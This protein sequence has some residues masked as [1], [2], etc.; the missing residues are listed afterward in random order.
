MLPGDAWHGAPST[1]PTTSRRPP[2]SGEGHLACPQLPGAGGCGG[3]TAQGWQRCRRSPGPPRRAGG[4]A[5]AARS[6]FPALPGASLRLPP[7]AARPLPPP[8][9]SLL[10][11]PGPSL[12]P[13]PSSLLPLPPSLLPRAAVG[14]EGCEAELSRQQT[15]A[16]SL[17]EPAP[18]PPSLPPPSP[19]LPAPIP[20]ASSKPYVSGKLG[21]GGDAD[22]RM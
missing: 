6:C 13:P 21:R 14:R 4:P 5:R 20:G 15:P 8:G 11:P 17:A 16:R 9:P 19:L 12:L 22:E 7:S 10:P 3:E 2:P 18:R 1:Q